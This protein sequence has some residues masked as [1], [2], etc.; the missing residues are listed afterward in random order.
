MSLKKSYY[1][2]IQVLKLI[3]NKIKTSDYEAKGCLLEII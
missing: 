1:K 2:A 3:D